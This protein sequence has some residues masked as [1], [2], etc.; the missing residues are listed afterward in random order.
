MRLLRLPLP[1][2]LGAAA[3]VAGVTGQAF[4]TTVGGTPAPSC[5]V[6]AR[7]ASASTLPTPPA[8]PRCF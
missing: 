3:L 5:V 8:P 7:P 6:K 1:A 4:A 2:V